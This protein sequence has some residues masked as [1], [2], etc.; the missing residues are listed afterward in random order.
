MEKQPISRKTCPAYRRFMIE[1]LDLT[2][3]ELETIF[4]KTFEEA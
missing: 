4:G 2:R 1:W 3:Q